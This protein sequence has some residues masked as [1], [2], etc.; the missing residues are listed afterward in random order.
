MSSRHW[1]SRHPDLLLFP[2]GACAGKSRVLLLS[3]CCRVRVRRLASKR[4]AR[5]HAMATSRPSVDSSCCQQHDV[6]R[7]RRA[8]ELCSP[9]SL[10]DTQTLL[11]CRPGSHDNLPSE[12][13]HSARPRGVTGG[14]KWKRSIRAITVLM[15]C[16]MASLLLSLSLTSC[17]LSSDF[18]WIFFVPLSL[19]NPPFF[20]RSPHP[21]SFSLHLHSLPYFVTFFL[22]ISAVSLVPLP[23]HHHL[24]SS[25][26][27]LSLCISV[28]LS[29]APLWRCSDL[30]PSLDRVRS[31]STT[32]LRPDFHSTD[33]DRYQKNTITSICTLFLMES[34]NFLG[35]RMLHASTSLHIMC[36]FHTWVNS[37]LYTLI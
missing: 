25:S 32:C 10:P 9:R 8:A 7:H 18:L 29:A 16:L 22:T 35:V 4:H 17:Y 26:H 11:P 12:W 28:S 36:S 3:S 24:A 27:P 30:Q 20:T 5:R 34:F 15:R 33:R 37:P 23:T 14:D 19:I 21:F 1:S 6:T 2:F 31:A 13:S